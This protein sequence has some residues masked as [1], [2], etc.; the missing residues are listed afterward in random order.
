MD[1]K[2]EIPPGLAGKIR[3]G[4]LLCSLG[5][6]IL[7]CASRRDFFRGLDNTV[8]NNEFEAAIS[9]IREGQQKKVPAYPERNAVSLFLDKGM[10]EY[11]AGNYAQSALDLQE[12]ERLIQEAFTKSVTADIA[13]YIAND[14]TKEYPGEDFEDIYLSVFNAL[15]YY[16]QGDV[17]G[18]LVEIRK[19]T[20]ASGKLDMLSRKY[21]DAGR[22]AGEYAKKEFGDIDIAI[23]EG[24]GPVEFSN[25]ALARYLS[26]LFYLADGN[27]DSARIELGRLVDA[28]SNRKMYRHSIPGAIAGIIDVPDGKARLNVIAF[29]GLSPVKIEEQFVQYWPLMQNPELR[30]PVFKLPAFIDRDHSGIQRIEVTV[31]GEK[32]ELE[33]LEDMGLVMKET[34]SAKFMNLFLK[35]Y[36]RVMIKYVAADIAALAAAQ[37]EQYGELAR[38]LTANGARATVYASESADIRMGRFFP[39]KAYVGGINLAPGAYDMIVRFPGGH[40]REIAVE[41]KANAVN[42]VDVVSLR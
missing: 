26:V 9:A 2:R 7:S 1:K 23:P 8:I 27:K 5:L 41:V 10:L 25:S 32:F 21:E 34:F 22:N 13:S 30:T 18:A 37:S 35:T 11:Y 29:T 33:L 31:N 28:F 15:N 16:K 3:S 36:I 20:M 12:A 17:E 4:L 39:N 19:L 24:K 14:N 42:L 6:S 38:F 40:T